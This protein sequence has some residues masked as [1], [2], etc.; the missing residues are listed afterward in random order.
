MTR[1]AV[2][3]RQVGTWLA[4]VIDILHRGLAVHSGSGADRGA[5][6]TIGEYRLTC[7]GGLDAQIVTCLSDPEAIA[8]RLGL[9][10]PGVPA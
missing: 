9:I 8:L 3:G 10:G 1:V 4:R 2:K 6:G 7:V 5:P